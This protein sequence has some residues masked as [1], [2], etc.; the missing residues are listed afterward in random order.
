MLKFQTGPLQKPKAQ[1]INRDVRAGAPLD[2][3]LNIFLWLV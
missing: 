3:S 1:R 2:I